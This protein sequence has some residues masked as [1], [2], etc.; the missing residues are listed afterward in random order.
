MKKIKNEMKHPNDVPVIFSYDDQGRI[1]DKVS[2]NEWKQKMKKSQL[3]EEFDIKLYRAAIDYYCVKDF[4][5]AVDLLLYLIANT[6]YTH[7]EYVERLANIYH[8]EKQIKKEKELLI[9]ARKHIEPVELS[10]GVLQRIDKRL[11]NLDNGGK[12]L[13]FC[14]VLSN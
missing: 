10:I 1:V 6:N 5:K 11:E 14:S 4:S 8:Q 13:S 9:T 12:H 7:Y 2:V 3:L